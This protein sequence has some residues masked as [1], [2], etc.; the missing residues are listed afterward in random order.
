MNYPCISR[1]SAGNSWLTTT[2]SRRT[3][4]ICLSSLI[5][6]LALT[7]GLTTQVRAETEAPEPPEGITTTLSFLPT[8][9]AYLQRR[10][11]Y[12][13]NY[14][15]VMTDY[16]VS[17]L[18]FTV[19]GLSVTDTVLSAT[20]QL[21]E[22]GDS[23]SGTLRV[24]RGSH[25]NWRENNLST[26]NAPTEDGQVGTFTG[27]VQSA[28]IVNI[29]VTPLITGDGTYSVIVKL[30]PGGNDIRFGSSEGSRKPQ[31]IIET[32][33]VTPITHTLTVNSGSGS[34]SYVAG[35]IVNIV[36]NA[37]PAGQEFD[38][39]TGDVA[40]V[41]N[42]D[43]SSTSI[44]MPAANATVSATYKPRQYTLTVNSG[45]GSGS[46]VAGTV[47]NIVANA[48]PTGQEFDKWTGDV[49]NVANVN[50]SST[51]ISMPAANATVSATYKPRQYTLTVNSGS[52]SGSYVA[53]TTVNIVANAAP[54]GQE[55]DKWT[56]DVANVANVDAS[57]TSISMPAANA[58]V[59]A[60]YKPR[61]YTLTVNSGSGSG[62]YVAGTTVNIVANA[63]PTGQEFDK[64]TGDVANVANVSASSTS[65]SMPAANA[66]VS[67]TYK[68]LPPDEYTLTVN[69][70]SGSGS[71]VAGTTVNIVA[72]A[73]PTGQEFDKWTGDVANV[74][75]VNASS[76]SIS[77]PAANATVSATYKA[78]PPDEYTLTVNSGS[79]SGS[80]VAGTT[81]NIVANAAPAGQE[82]DKWTGD[83]ANVA[84][85]N[86][87]STSISMPAANAT[88]SATYKA[89]PP[90]EYTLTVNSGSGSGSYVAGT[91]VNIVANAA[92]AGQEFDKWTGDV[93]NVANVNASSTS[94]SMPAANATVSAT[95]KALP[96][97]EYT[98]TVNSGSGSGS[99]VAGTIV[100]IVANAAPSG[101]EFDK[102]TGD[103]A[104]V[105]NVNA[106][107]TSISMPAANA[108]VSA[109]YKALPPMDG[110]IFDIGPIDGMTATGNAGM[111]TAINGIPVSG[112]LL[113]ETVFPNPND[114]Y[115]AMNA[116]NFDLSALGSADGQPYF[117]CFFEQAVMTI[118]FIENGG[119]D[120]GFMQALDAA[121]NPVGP[122]VSFSTGDYLK[123]SYLSGNNQVVAGLA[124]WM[125]APVFGVRVSP[126]IEV[127]M[128]FDPISISASVG[129]HLESRWDASG[130]NWQLL[131]FG[132]NWVLQET[133]DWGDGWSDV[134]P[135]ASS[136]YKVVPEGSIRLFRLREVGPE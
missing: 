68:A 81:V 80:Y 17:Y 41:A 87:S 55:F 100:N 107:S 46:Y 54:T 56:G 9:D 79:G 65:I 75:N 52:G 133:T 61:Q 43:A 73:A 23:G 128:G 53:G 130:G 11:R 42:V 12:N 115:P 94:I 49:A 26:S 102:W 122:I 78:L 36:A 31:L 121:G 33:P 50:A 10:T 25:N 2:I 109:T 34:G 74:A 29:D 48:P 4:R 120:S 88:V 92:P 101:Q 70:G 13:N 118:F 126:P 62:S 20:L 116:D 71:Y 39:W 136:P 132:E 45:S 119:N 91:T 89:L 32:Q 64:W 135:A 106:S 134:S 84:N 58:T 129:P 77:M 18:K 123:T 63:P 19:T 99:Y 3:E 131:W 1:D 113:G 97:D 103:V 8:D 117:E 104:N 35:T 82:F 7:L 5:P 93:A 112:L 57:S 127:A 69:S 27:T 108:T 59:S 111:I 96:P 24:Y 110:G 66:T 125:A 44:S 105:A 28:Q 72:N 22:H 51:S 30:D 85:V 6:I 67:A 83:V 15:R 47:V 38:K 90:D 114:V 76:T 95:Y 98:L 86:A 40:N 124:V 14:L 21:Q 60:T 16:Q 37:P